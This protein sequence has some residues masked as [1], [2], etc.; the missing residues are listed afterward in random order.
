MNLSKKLLLIGS[1]LFLGFGFLIVKNSSVN[2]ALED[3][4]GFGANFEDC[5]IGDIKVA[6][7][8]SADTTEDALIDTI[9]TFIN[10]VLGILALITLVILLRGGFQ[11]VTATGDDGKYKEG[12]KIL[13]QAAMGLFFIGLSRLIVSMIFWIIGLV[14]GSGSGSSSNTNQNTVSLNISSSIL[15]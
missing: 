1:F 6:G 8:A 14:T 4:S 5:G 13:K 15:G 9:K 11:M 7:T 12:F 10:R 2:A 3:C